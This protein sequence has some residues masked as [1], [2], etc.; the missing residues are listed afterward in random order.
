MFEK[1]SAEFSLMLIGLMRMSHV[2]LRNTMLD[3]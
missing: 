1:D 2:E 3:T